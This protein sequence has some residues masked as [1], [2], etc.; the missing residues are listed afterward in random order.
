VINVWDTLKPKWETAPQGS[1]IDVLCDYIFRRFKYSYL[2]LEQLEEVQAWIRIGG[3]GSSNSPVLL[4]LIG[5]PIA[6][7]VAA[8]KAKHPRWSDAAIIDDPHV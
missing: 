3:C 2:S 7:L 4:E 1:P 8:E 5:A 6:Q